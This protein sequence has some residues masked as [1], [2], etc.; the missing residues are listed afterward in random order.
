MQTVQKTTVFFTHALKLAGNTGMMLLGIV[1]LLFTASGGVLAPLSP[2]R[3]C[4][5]S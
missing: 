5:L 4:I 1:F 2:D 3:D